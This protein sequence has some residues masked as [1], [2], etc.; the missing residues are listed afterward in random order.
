MNPRMLS[1]LR[2]SRGLSQSALAREAKVPQ[3]AISRAE[4]GLGELDP[5]RV[6]AIADVLDYP[7][8]ALNWTDEVLGFGSA[9]FHHR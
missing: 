3:S 7:L 5:A 4:N 1:L 8:E 9:S 6:Q 2:E